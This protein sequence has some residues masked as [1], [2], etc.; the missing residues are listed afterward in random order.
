M[1]LVAHQHLSGVVLGSCL[2]I[3]MSITRLVW[4]IFLFILQ[5]GEDD[6]RELSRNPHN[7]LLWFHP[8]FVLEVL[9]PKASI[10]DDG[11]PCSLDDHRPE[12]HVPPEGF[13]AMYGLLAAAVARWYQAEVGCKLVLVVESF[14]GFNP[15]SYNAHYKHRTSLLS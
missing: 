10:P 7:R 1:K 8:L 2:I 11:Y 3:R 15:P 5:Y 9:Y 6:V 14:Y 12:L 13:L 4:Y